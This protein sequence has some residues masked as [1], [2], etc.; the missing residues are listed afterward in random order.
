MWV[1]FFILFVFCYPV[2]IGL[3]YILGHSDR[4]YMNKNRM[5]RLF[6]SYE[7]QNFLKASE[8]KILSSALELKTKKVSEVMTPIHRAFMLDVNQNMDENLKREIYMQGYSRIPVFEGTRDNIVGILMTKD[9]ILTNIDNTLFTI[10]QLSSILV[11]DVIAIDHEMKLEPI[12]GF[13]KGGNSHMAV[14]TKV[15]EEPGMDPKLTKIGIV[16]LED[17]IEEILQEEIEDEREAVDF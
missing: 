3:D 5:K 10:R 8:R 13:F 14:V 1:Y 16:T 17:I 9:L 6:E 15:V 7:T 2:G 12:L 11:R 4:G